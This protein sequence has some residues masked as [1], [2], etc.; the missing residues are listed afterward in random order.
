MN[1][2]KKANEFGV[3]IRVLLKLL[4]MD[5]KLDMEEDEYKRGLVEWYRVVGSV[6]N[7]Q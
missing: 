3:F 2:R 7:A 4:T 5:S 1:E 6:A